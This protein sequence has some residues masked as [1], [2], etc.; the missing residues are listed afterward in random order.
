MVKIEVDGDTTAIEYQGEGVA[1]SIDI[2]FAMKA[3]VDALREIG[4]SDSFIR[5][6]FEIS[7]IK[8]MEKLNE[9]KK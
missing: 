5:T 2:C 1:L 9:E 8:D 7:M 6:A 3:T 4:K